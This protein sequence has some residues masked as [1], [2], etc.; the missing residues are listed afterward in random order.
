MQLLALQYMVGTIEEILNYCDSIAIVGSTI[1]IVVTC[2]T[3]GYIEFSA[4]RPPLDQWR[5]Y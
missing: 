1:A 2:D 4:P 3:I 5:V